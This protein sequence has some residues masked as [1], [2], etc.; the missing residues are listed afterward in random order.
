MRQARP[1]LPL[2]LVLATALLALAVVGL[3]AYVRLSDAGLGCPDWPGCYGEPTPHHA[4]GAIAAA[5]ALDPAG[6]VSPAKAWKEM[7]H[8]YLASGLGLAILTIAWMAWRRER[9]INRALALGLAGLVV[10]QGLLGMWTVT[11]LLRPVVVSAHLLG[12]LAT[13]ALLVWLAARLAA[14]HQFTMP[15]LPRWGARV[16]LALVVLQVALGGWVSANYA[17][18]ACADFPTCHGSWWPQ[19][20]WRGAFQV[21][22][23]LGLDAQG[24]ALSLEALIAMHWAHRLGALAATLAVGWLGWRLLGQPAWR[25]WAVALL[26]LLGMQLALGVANVLA[27]LPLSVAVAHNLGAALLLAGLVWVSVRMRGAA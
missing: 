4:A 27:G 16:A 25:G 3:G 23:E 1:P 17:A 11:L 15:G 24:Q 13:L 21:H 2:G 19:A 7:S 22:R 20:D 10:F 12:G 6:P 26:G 8:R 5:H 9:G 18:L 14:G